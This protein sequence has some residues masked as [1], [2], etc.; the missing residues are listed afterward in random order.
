MNTS[1]TPENR[2][3]TAIIE[4]VRLAKDA[5]LEMALLS[6]DN[7][8]KALAAC[9]SALQEA[10]AE[11]LAANRSDMEKAAVEGISPA[12][13]QRL[14]FD[15]PKL[16]GAIE[17]VTQL[18]S[19]PDPIAK[20]LMAT[21]LA[22]GLEL[23]R[24]SVPIGLIGV[25]FEARPDA[26]IQ[27]A[28]LCLKSGNA[29]ILKGGSEARRSN[30]CLFEVM[31]KAGRSAGLPD[32]WIT[33]LEDRADVSALLSLDVYVDLLI[34]RGS[35]EFVQHIMSN[36]KIPVL[37]HADGV[38]HTYIDGEC[39]QDLALQVAI[40]AKTQYVSV[41]NATETIL[42]DD[43][44]WAGDFIERLELA[45]KSKG[46]RIFA[47]TRLAERLNCAV[48]EDWHTEYLDL[49]VSLKMVAGLDAAIAHINRYGS[50]HTDAIL[51]ENRANAEQ[52]MQ[53]VD[54]GNVFW[55]CS[56]R[57][58]DGFRYGFGAEVGV[59]TSKIH[60]RGPVGL[61]GLLTYKYKLYGHGDKVA[62]FSEG[63]RKFTH[64][65]LGI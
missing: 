17:G 6:H 38:C 28:A 56:T 43:A 44:L 9:A 37:G 42:I 55:N 41:C 54:S 34:P 3:S 15:E 46:V 51:T 10:R 57:F 13:L 45:L 31:D 1:Q 39:D 14:K 59:S 64:Q 49:A 8:Q 19:L 20:K 50:K 35:N 18:Q 22:P 52:F 5:A 63:V 29:L 23:F 47:D 24:V 2:A 26:L 12:I 33:L 16:A 11:I 65:S 4:R 7:R 32:G 30:R 25:V 60:A 48:T 61:E 40:D 58:S 62:D 53:A 21:E 27:I 36:T